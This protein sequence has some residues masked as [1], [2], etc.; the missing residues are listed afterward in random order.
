MPKYVKYVALGAVVGALCVVALRVSAEQPVFQTASLPHSDQQADVAAGPEAPSDPVLEP[1]DYG[2]IA[3]GFEV[4]EHRIRRNETFAEILTAHNVPYPEIVRV[5]DMAR[6][7]F[8]V[9]RMQAGRP[10]RIYRDSLETARYL[11][12]EQDAV[13]FVVFDLADSA[14]V[15]EGAREVTVERKRLEGEIYS[16]LYETLG[17]QELAPSLVPVLAGEL[18]E[19]FAWQIDFFRIQKGEAFTVIYEEKSIDGEPVGI[20]RILAARF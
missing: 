16:S 19:V 18:S 5:A 11:I 12:Y 9:R 6:P 8:D 15:Y 2:I 10:I 17:G 14:R 4:L 7:Q 20:G 13:N 1:D 3:Q